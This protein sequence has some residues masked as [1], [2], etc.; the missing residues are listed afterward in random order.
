MSCMVGPYKLG[1]RPTR[2]SAGVDRFSKCMGKAGF[3]RERDGL[4]RHCVIQKGRAH[5]PLARPR[6]QF[7]D[8]TCVKEKKRTKAKKKNSLL[9]EEVL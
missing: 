2:S 7:S 5:P 9:L 8:M 6:K 1:S 3:V 4:R